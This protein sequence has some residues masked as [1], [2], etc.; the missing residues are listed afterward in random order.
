VTPLVENLTQLL[1]GLRRQVKQHD[2]NYEPTKAEIYAL[3]TAV[4]LLSAD[5]HQQ[6]L[7]KQ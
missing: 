4:V 3:E 7:Q 2:D 6:L 1:V 5:Q